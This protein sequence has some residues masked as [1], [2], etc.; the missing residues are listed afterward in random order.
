MVKL[1]DIYIYICMLTQEL[2]TIIIV[3]Y[4]F[5]KWLYV[6]MHGIKYNCRLDF[7][8]GIRMLIHSAGFTY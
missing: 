4:M 5:L 6:R 3:F 8:I 2:I 1:K 7:L